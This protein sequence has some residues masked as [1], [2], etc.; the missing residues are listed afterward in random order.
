MAHDD[1]HM[2]GYG[3]DKMRNSKKTGNPVSICRCR[4]KRSYRGAYFAHVDS[5]RLISIRRNSH[6]R[7]R[8]WNFG[9]AYHGMSR[10]KTKTSFQPPRE[11]SDSCVWWS[12]PR[13]IFGSNGR[14]KGPFLSKA[15]TQGRSKN[16]RF[17]FPIDPPGCFIMIWTW[18]NRVSMNS[19]AKRRTFFR[20]DSLHFF[21]PLVARAQFIWWKFCF[22]H[23]EKL[24]VRI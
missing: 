10:Q 12:G 16:E 5:S 19:P 23:C 14:R 4:V 15:I 2:F 7:C 18:C 13:A 24:T 3:S 21:E 22:R 11:Q 20:G 9:L 17:I 6:V 8:I 1:T